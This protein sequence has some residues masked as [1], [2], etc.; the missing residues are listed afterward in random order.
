MNYITPEQ[1]QKHF[2]VQG[3]TIAVTPSA[4][5]CARV[6]GHSVDYST[7]KRHYYDTVILDIV[8]GLKFD[9]YKARYQYMWLKTAIE[10]AKSGANIYVKAPITIL[11]Q[12]NRLCYKHFVK[13]VTMEDGNTYLHITLQKP[14]GKKTKIKYSTGEEISFDV[15]KSILPKKY[16]QQHLDY[17]NLV[18]SSDKS[19]DY[20]SV[21]CVAG[22]Q[23]H[24]FFDLY[25]ESKENGTYGLLVQN[26]TK[27][28]QVSKLEDQ[29]CNS[30]ADIYFF[31][32]KD[33]RDR[34]FDLFTK[35]DIIK[36]SDNLACGGEMNKKVQS[37]LMN[38]LIFNYAVSN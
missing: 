5:L 21:T 6:L 29:C 12:V 19:V 22:R 9:G 10:Y 33:Q 38:P 27:K 37:Y 30:S 34:Y 2:T 3:D 20:S 36:L 31:T 16:N 14:S 23:R 18:D 1:F 28:L 15:S 25:E 26:N 32:S 7:E 11:N 13:S 8:E 35:Y 17:L 4:S 24:L